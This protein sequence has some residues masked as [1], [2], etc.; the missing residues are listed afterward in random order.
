MIASAQ[1]A[2]TAPTS[3]M[4]SQM[5]SALSSGERRKRDQTRPQ[6]RLMGAIIALLLIVLFNLFQH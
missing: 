2:C 4:P 3:G 1:M 6:F 5:G